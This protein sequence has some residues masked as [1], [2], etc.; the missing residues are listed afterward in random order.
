LRDEVF[1]RSKRDALSTMQTGSY[2]MHPTLPTDLFEKPSPWKIPSGGAAPNDTPQVPLPP[3]LPGTDIPQGPKP[4][5]VL[6]HNPLDETFATKLSREAFV[7]GGGVGQSFFYG[8]ANLPDHMP[9][10]A[11]SIVM[12][13]TLAAMTKAGKLGA[14]ASLVIG[15][16]FASRFVLDT[17]HDHRRWS[18]FSEAVQDTWKSDENT[19]RNLHVVRNT[20]G[21]YA[22][23]T[24]ISMASGYIG[25]KNPQLGQWILTVLRVPP[26]VPNAPPP[27]SPRLAATS[28]ALSIMPPA[29]FYD[30]YGDHSYGGGWHLDIKLGPRNNVLSRVPDWD[31]DR[32][33]DRRQDLLYESDRN[34]YERDNW[35]DDKSDKRKR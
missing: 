10:I 29:G 9:Q 3:T 16:Y 7:I 1:E 28:M 33:D 20:V 8:I 22:F 34:R 19:W 17:F 4:G 11:S 26:I 13:G 24:S 23:D 21:N 18:K 12:G 30:K 35:D 5:D 15:T 14:A 27:F 6:K 2:D 31:R 25:Y 32:D